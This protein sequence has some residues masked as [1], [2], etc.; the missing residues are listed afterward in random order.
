MQRMRTIM[1]GVLAAVV[2]ALP[3]MATPNDDE[4]GIRPG[5]LT[6]WLDDWSEKQSPEVS[7]TVSWTLRASHEYL[8]C[9]LTNTSKHS[10]VLNGNLLPWNAFIKITFIA[11][12][13]AGRAVLLDTRPVSFPVPMPEPLV[14]GAGHFIEGDIDFVKSFFYKVASHE[15]IFLFWRASVTPYRKGAMPWSD[16]ESLELHMSGITLISKRLTANGS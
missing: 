5:A 11:Y 12:N 14:L 13:A 6:Q 2:F 7:M 15:D 8:H 3:C 1:L 4:L 10:I 9:R 16:T